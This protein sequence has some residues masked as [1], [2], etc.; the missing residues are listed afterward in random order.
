MSQHCYDLQLRWKR[1]AGD[2]RA[3]NDAARNDS[4]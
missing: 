1:S 2:C 4:A 3:A